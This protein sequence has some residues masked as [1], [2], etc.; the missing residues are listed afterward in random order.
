MCRLFR[1]VSDRYRRWRHS[2]G[3]GVHSPFA[4]TLV[5]EALYPAMGYAYYL[6][7]DPRLDS[8]DPSESRRARSLYRLALRLRQLH[9]D[10]LRIYLWSKAPE[11]YRRALTLAGG[12]LLETPSP[13]AI[14]ILDP[15]DPEAEAKAEPP[16]DHPT[17]I[18]PDGGTLTFESPHYTIIIPRRQMADTSYRLP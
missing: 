3:Y 2:R 10:P 6:E 7:H 11:C 15:R 8:E 14:L 9:A 1:S 12:R 13:S 5:K 16:H 18:L 17:C 4:Y